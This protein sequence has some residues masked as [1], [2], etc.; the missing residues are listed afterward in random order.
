MIARWRVPGN[1]KPMRNVR[2]MYVDGDYRIEVYKKKHK[3]TPW[4]WA[5]FVNERR[6]LESRDH[7]LYHVK[8]RAVNEIERHR[9][10]NGNS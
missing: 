8:Y 5:M 4:I 3:V 6:V 10:N 9:S 2:L 1:V 7:K